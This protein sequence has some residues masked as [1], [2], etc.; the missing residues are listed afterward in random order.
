M[1]EIW[2]RS[3]GWKDPLVAQLQAGT[4]DLIWPE[5]KEQQGK[6]S[7]SSRPLNH[8]CCHPMG[9]ASL[10]TQQG[11]GLCQPH[12]RASQ[13][14]AHCGGHTKCTF[15]VTSPIPQPALF[16]FKKLEDF[17]KSPGFH[18]EGNGNPLQCSCPENPRDRGAWWAAV[19]GVSQSRTE[20][21]MAGWNH[22]LDGRESG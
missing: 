14:A 17:G 11:G 13:H 7:H 19:S 9:K 20:D 6:P 12:V 1:K 5:Q 2:V 10:R 4:C 8:I 16:A 3:L 18:G 22:W 21:E 15:L